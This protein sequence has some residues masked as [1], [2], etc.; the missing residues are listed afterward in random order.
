MKQFFKKGGLFLILLVATI[1]SSCEKDLYEE[2]IKKENAE[3]EFKIR[4]VTL[5][6][7]P[8]ID[9]E[10]NSIKQLIKSKAVQKRTIYDFNLNE[11]QIKE[12]QLANGDV[13]YSF[14][15]EKQ[16]LENT[17]YYLENLE[18]TVKDSGYDAYIIKWIPTDGNIFAGIDKFTGEIQY[19]DLDGRLLQSVQMVEGLFTQ[20]RLIAITI[21]CVDYVIE[22]DSNGNCSIVS[23][24]NHCGSG[25]TSGGSNSS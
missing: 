24:Y 8:E 25:S 14:I 5:K 21:G 12:L 17:A 1:F 10:L 19:Q 16:L 11:E 2:A 23:T 3:H 9:D 18:I 7:I 4:N 22:Q 6:M 13:N 20:S 15:V